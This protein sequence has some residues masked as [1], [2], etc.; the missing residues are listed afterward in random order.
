MINNPP[1]GFEIFKDTMI[2]YLKKNSN[3]YKEFLKKYKKI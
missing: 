2:D 3:D 1:I